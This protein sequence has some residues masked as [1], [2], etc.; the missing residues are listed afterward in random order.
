MGVKIDQI[1]SAVMELVEENTVIMGG[2]LHE[3]STIIE[4]GQGEKAHNAYKE[5][6]GSHR[7]H[8]EYFLCILFYDFLHASVV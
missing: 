8:S 1:N 7:G 2:S 3:S 5:G 6:D 4:W